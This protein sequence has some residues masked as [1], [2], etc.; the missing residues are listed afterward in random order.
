M[1]REN[2]KYWFTADEH[3]GHGELQKYRGFESVS[4]MKGH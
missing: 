4:E 2:P 3:Y 1:R